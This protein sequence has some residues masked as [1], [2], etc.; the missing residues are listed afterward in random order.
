MLLG[1]DH[2]IIAVRDLTEAST[3]MERAL[4]LRFSPGGEHPE[5][6]TQNAVARLGTDYLEL[7]SVHQPDTARS[8]ERGRILL[9]YLR[10]HESGPLGFALTSDDLTRDTVEARNRGLELEDTSQGYRRRPDGAVVTWQ[11]ASAPDDPWGRRIPFLIQHGTAMLQRRGWE[12]PESNPLAAS[13]VHSAGVL[14][15]DLDET[16]DQYRS[17]LGTPPDS[18]TKLQ[19]MAA[20]SAIFCVES[21]RIELLQTAAPSGR[22]AERPEHQ[23]E[24][25]WQLTL[26]VAD[27]DASVRFLR[28]RGT[29][30]GSPT[31]QGV[32]SLQDPD[33]S[34]GVAIRLVQGY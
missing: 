12:A 33:Q 28:A 2:A 24:G 32:A 13:A 6:G 23:D 1:L 22:P 7:I 31:A 21:F 14:V 3:Q 18:V 8:N 29:A 27:V 25:L 26:A 34:L 4:G 17:L 20:R 5:W 10:D 11:T 15:V 19:A 9:D 30:V 16:I